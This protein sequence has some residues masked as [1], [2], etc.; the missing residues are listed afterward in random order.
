MAEYNSNILKTLGDM[1]TQHQEGVVFVSEKVSWN[2]RNVTK[3]ARKNYLGIYDE[4]YDPITGEEKFFPPLTE[5]FTDG[6]IKSIDVDLK[7]IDLYSVN[8]ANVGAVKV[9]KL[10]VKQKLK[11]AGFSET[12]NELIRYLC[13]D[14]SAVLKFIDG[15]KNGKRAMLIK[16]VDTLNLIADQ[17]ACNLDDCFGVLERS[18]LTQDELRAKSGVWYNIEE[19]LKYT[20]EGSFFRQPFFGSSDVQSPAPY[21]PIYDYWGQVEKCWIT[22]K[23]SDEGVWTEGHIVTCNLQESGKALILFAELNNT[24]K[25]PYEDVSLKKVIGRRQGRGIPEMLFGTQKY[26]NMLIDIRKKNAQI[27]QNGL[28]KAKKNSGLTADSIIS[29][30][31]AGGIIP[32]NEMDDFEQMPITDSR[33]AS[34][35]DEDRLMAWGER[36]TGQYD[37]RRGEALAASAPATTQ[38]IQDRNSKDLYQLVQ[39]NLGLM[40][41]RFV[42]K[43]VIPWVIENVKDE[44]VVMITGSLKDL[45]EMDN[46]VAEYLVN[47]Q[48]SKQINRT[49]QY[50]TPESIVAAKDAQMK[51]FKLQGARRYIEIKKKMFEGAETGVQVVITNEAIDRAT[52]LAKLQEVLTL[53]VSSQGALNIDPQGVIDTMFDLMNVPTDRLY[54]QRSTYPTPIDKMSL[55]M[56][57]MAAAMPAQGMN[58]MTGKVAPQ[59]NADQGFQPMNMIQSRQRLDTGV[60]GLR[61]TTTNE[62]AL[63]Q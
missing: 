14:G 48:V 21:Y 52:I 46:A 19:A 37:V 44:E 3:R 12:L 5:A 2:M 41:E 18:L 15:K 58:Q 40:L 60:P 26:M 51:A 13:I 39:E 50:P 56:K 61:Q 32:V 29:K 36:S 53:A 7:D 45:D 1:L 16:A 55:A 33:A 11:E 35:G 38:L 47:Q 8:G 6:V 17:S 49:K 4:P 20:P 42:E 24:G 31:A 10:L 28:F 62:A 22:N 57:K 63:P 25:R 9:L 30:I 23:D 43:H 59:A 27:L 34:Y 54:T